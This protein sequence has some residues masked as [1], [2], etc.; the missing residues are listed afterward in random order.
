[1]RP[2]VPEI[3]H[4]VQES[5]DGSLSR[6]A[7]IGAGALGALASVPLVGRMFRLGDALGSPSKAQDAKILQLVLQLEYMQV[8]F[9]SQALAQGSLKG[10]LRE[11]ARAALA[12]ERQHLAA[13]RK[14]LGAKAGPKPTFE[15]GGQTKTAAAFTRAARARRED[16]IA[17]ESSAC[18]RSSRGAMVDALH[19][20]ADIL[21]RAGVRY[22]VIGFER[23][24]ALRAGKG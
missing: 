13:I 20:V 11:F 14:A 1:M 16:P 8:A 17:L 12:H 4:C 3:E 18:T 15:F 5:S 2:A 23:L 6:R 24:A 19:S 22:A 21:A 10:D 9:Y 7:L